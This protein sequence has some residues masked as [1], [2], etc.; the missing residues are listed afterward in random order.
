MLGDS[1]RGSGSFCRARAALRGN[2]KNRSESGVGGRENCSAAGMAIDGG[3]HGR[4]TTDESP[5]RSREVVNPHTWP[6]CAKLAE[7]RRGER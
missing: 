7:I 1:R 3:D 4:N 5:R 2:G 6:G